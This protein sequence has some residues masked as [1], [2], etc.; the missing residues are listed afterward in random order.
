ML[1]F[2]RGKTSGPAA[3]KIIAKAPKHQPKP[4]ASA[5]GCYAAIT[6]PAKMHLMRL[7]DACSVADACGLRSVRSVPQRYG[8]VHQSYF[9]RD[10]FTY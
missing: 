6:A 3:I 10:N 2:F 7:Y 8:Y 1:F 4:E 5:R 9:S